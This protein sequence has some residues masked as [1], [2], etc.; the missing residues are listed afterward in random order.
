[1]SIDG[2][3]IYDSIEERIRK[4]EAEQRKASS[5]V[6]DCENQINSLVSEREKAYVTL[7]L[8]YL[9]ELSAKSVAETL[10]EV[11][12][13]VQRL[14]AEK[15]RRRKTLEQ[16]MEDL[17]SQ[18]TELQAKLKS[19]T[20]S[21]NLKVQERETMV[22]QIKAD[23]AKSPEYKS[24]AETVE[25][26]RKRL[27]KNQTRLEIFSV[28]AE[29]KLGE[30]KQDKIFMYLLNKGF[31]TETQAKPSRLDAWVAKLIDYSKQLENYNYLTE[32]P[33][34]M[35]AE[36]DKRKS[37]F[38]KLASKLGIFQRKLENEHGLPNLVSEGEKLLAARNSLL[39]KITEYDQK[40]NEE[41]QEVRELDSTKDRYHREAISRLKNYLQSA[42]I[43]KLKELARATPGTDDDLLVDRIE[44]I[45]LAMRE[46]KDTSK[47]AQKKRN[48]ISHNLEGLKRILGEFESNDY[49]SSRSEFES[50]FD[51]NTILTWY[52]IGKLSHRDVMNRIE[53]SQHFRP[54]QEYHSYSSSGGSS[55]NDDDDSSFGSS[56]HS[57][58][59]S[60]SS[61]GFSSGGGFGGGGHS[62]GSGF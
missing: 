45:D 1:M 57:S 5:K 19:T 56:S 43:G 6:Y 62:S 46:Y 37:A 41:S 21:L 42:E 28:E 51:I 18:K 35:E 30:Y 4:V 14:F 20:A 48:E 50:D 22:I 9:P 58:G 53:E 12:D 16:E 54:R 36:L 29:A 34:Q 60:F 7:A 59:S 24:L 13:T 39:E 38:S 47:Q 3:S 31:G 32:M 25:A 33:A 15:Q 52:L 11:Q 49:E 40:Y 55:S 27:A 26:E 44:N 23:I 8:K 61:S 2:S 10:N 17:Q